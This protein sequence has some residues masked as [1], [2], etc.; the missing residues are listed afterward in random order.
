MK[1]VLI[2]ALIVLFV[3]CSKKEIVG[4]VT[5]DLQVTFAHGTGGCFFDNTPHPGD[6]VVISDAK[7][8]TCHA[9]PHKRN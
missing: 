1:T 9:I 8:G 3:G 7:T 4:Q 5:D 6:D 2:L